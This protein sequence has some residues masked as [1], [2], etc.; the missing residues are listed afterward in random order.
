MNPTPK[1]PPVVQPAPVPPTRPAT[2]NKRGRLFYLGL[3]GVIGGSA[4]CLL[5]IILILVSFVAK[6]L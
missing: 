4:C 3:A 1:S 2:P 6:G 5:S